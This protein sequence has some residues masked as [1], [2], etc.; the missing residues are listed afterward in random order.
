MSHTQCLPKDWIWDARAL[1]KKQAE[2]MKELQRREAA[3]AE[4]KAK[5]AQKRVKQKKKEL[6]EMNALLQEQKK[7]QLRREAIMDREIE[8]MSTLCPLCGRYKDSL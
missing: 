5:E 4:E 6:E 8:S 3:D 7:E 2:E 1:K